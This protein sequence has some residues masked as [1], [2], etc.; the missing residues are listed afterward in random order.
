MCLYMWKCAYLL[1]HL[2]ARGQCCVMVLSCFTM[3]F[4]FFFGG[5][6]YFRHEPSHSASNLLR[7]ALSLTLEFK[8]S[9]EMVAGKLQGLF[10]LLP[11]SE[12]TGTQV[13]GGCWKSNAYVLMLLY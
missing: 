2:E 7:Q 11:S 5:G 9:E 8:D 13:L 12:I 4:R 6:Q 10:C 3:F 1:M